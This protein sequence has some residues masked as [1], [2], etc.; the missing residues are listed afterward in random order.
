MSH[1]PFSRL[2]NGAAPQNARRTTTHKFIMHMDHSQHLQGFLGTYKLYFY[3]NFYG[4][5]GE[6]KEMSKQIGV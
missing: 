4:S 1:I 3:N 5:G 6:E 2:E